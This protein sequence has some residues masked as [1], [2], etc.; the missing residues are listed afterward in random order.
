MSTGS[1]PDWPR[2]G[3]GERVVWRGQPHRWGVAK[4]A[5]GLLVTVVV[6]GFLE[7]A[8]LILW[9][10]TCVA[11]V[12]GA[13]LWFR[14]I[15]YAVTNR[16][17]YRREGLIDKNEERLPVADVLQVDRERTLLGNQLGYESVSAHTVG[18]TVTLGRVPD[19]EAVEGHIKAQ[20]DGPPGAGRT[21]AAVGG[22]AAD[23]VDPS[24]VER[25]R[26]EASR[27]RAVA[28]SLEDAVAGGEDG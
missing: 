16:R 6:F 14:N 2:L 15:E 20:S 3:D 22:E 13:H 8:S 28:V 24:E 17:V 23:G 21:T 11:L 4:L 9:L 26:E 27:I 5:L 18:R 25:V 1:D 7:P 12:A 10:P 19:P